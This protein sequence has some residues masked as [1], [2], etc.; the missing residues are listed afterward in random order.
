MKPVCLPDSLKTLLVTGAAD[1]AVPALT[2]ELLARDPVP[3]TVLLAHEWRAIES[4]M[5]A[6]ELFAKWS[7]RPAPRLE[8]L[9][10]LGGLEDD[11]PR[12]FELRCDVIAALTSLREAAPRQNPLEEPASPIVIAAT[13]AALLQACPDPKAM[14]RG[15]IKL[16]PGQRVSLTGLAERLGAE[17]GYD[18][19]AICETPGQFS[20]RGGLIDIYPLNATAP[21]RIDFFGDEIESIRT[22]DPTTQRSEETVPSLVIASAQAGLDTHRKGTLLDYLPARVRWILRQPDKLESAFADLFQIPENIAAPARSFQTVIKRRAGQDDE[23]LGL[24]DVEARQ[25]L[26]PESTPTRAVASESLEGYRTFADTDKL[27]V[28]RLEAGN[29]SREKFLAQI[30]DW[31]TQGH[32]VHFVCRTEGEETRLR[33]ILAESPTAKRIKADFLQGNLPEGFRLADG[34]E[35]HVYATESEIAGRQRLYVSRRRRKL[36]ERQQVDQLLD[37]SELANGDYLVHLQH[38]VC[39]FRG[40]Q[41]LN[42]GSKEEEVISLEFDEGITLHVRLH[43]SHLLSRYVGLTKRSPKLGRLGTN[44]WDKTRRAAERATLDLAAQLLSLQAE[45]NSRPGYAFSSDQPWQHAFEDAFPFRETPDQLTAIDQ[46]KADMEKPLPMDRLICGDVGFGKTEVA[47][48]AAMK[49]VLDGKQ[50]AVMLPTTVLCQQMFTNFKERFADYPIAVEMLS[51]FRTARQQSEIKRQLKQG[52]IDIVVGTHSLLGSSVKFRDL[53]LLVIDEEHRFGVRQKEKLK[54]MRH[55]IDVLSMSATPIPRTL[56]FALVGAR[57]MSVIETPPRDRLPIQTIVKAYDPKLVQ[58][59]IEF[60]VRRGGQVFYLHNRVTTIDVVARR[61][62][63]MMPDL[64]IGVG[65]G[66][67]EQGELEKVMTRFV[68]GEFDVLVSTTIIE[69]GLDIPNSN[70]IIIEGADRFG[71][72]QLYQLRGRVGRF[73]RQAYA[74]LLLHRHTRLLDVARKRLGAIR[75]FNQ[76]GAGFRIAMRDLELRGAG[77]ILGAQQSGHIAGVG[78]DLYCQLLRQSV[79]RLKGDS[80]AA[81]IRANV[82]LDFVLVGEYR[83]GED[84]AETPDRFH[85]LKADELADQR[86]EVVEAFIPVSYIGEARL[87]IDFYRRLAL[88]SSLEQISEAAAEMKDRFGPVPASVDYLLKMTEIRCLAERKGISLV[89]TEGNRLKCRLAGS[90]EPAFVKVGNRFPRLTAK[91]PLPK[92]NEIRT[93]LKTCQLT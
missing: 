25:N 78:F 46:T 10:D 21:L 80:T 74:Y 82:R 88:A 15:Q 76:L 24:T 37:F 18:S 90:R 17:L 35:K 71:L 68:A 44:A 22:F 61:L 56:Y 33:E 28:V 59:A 12:A 7:G 89:E 67:M 75:Q 31:Q 43:E 48:R 73:N 87:R 11:D 69:S 13:P 50:V 5:D 65:H 81:L 51:S 38:G 6:L 91:K 49:A 14:A 16:R 42:T 72:S 83:D 86:G 19:E 20:V 41:R 52:D 9:P 1:A 47:L 39:I 79:A 92:L 34:E 77:N 84:P 63:E 66:Q 23:W 55:D 54:I 62:Q 4:W 64:R 70:T 58:E 53:G 85:A 60:E 8:R 2:E 27:G 32:R 3:V 26:F 30:T 29:T 93:F 45:R 40:L 57:E 36:P